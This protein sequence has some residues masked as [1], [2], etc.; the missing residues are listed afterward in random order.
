MRTITIRCTEDGESELFVKP[1]EETTD[2]FVC[3]NNEYVY[4]SNERA[5]FLA[6]E[7]INHYKDLHKH[8]CQF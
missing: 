4:I 7:I 6:N 5:L 1:C 8:T 2:L 3:V